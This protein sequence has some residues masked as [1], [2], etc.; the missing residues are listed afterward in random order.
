LQ[1]ERNNLLRP[2]IDPPVEKYKMHNKG[3]QEA[4][5]EPNES[6]QGSRAGKAVSA[7]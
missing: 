3:N 5:V 7:S 4:I 1:L 6:E 2:A